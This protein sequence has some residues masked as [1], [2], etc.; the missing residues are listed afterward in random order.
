VSLELCSPEAPEGLRM[1]RK[2][3]G[4]T[5]RGTDAPEKVRKHRKR[6]GSTGRDTDAPE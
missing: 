5:G 6:Y 1:H 4:C 3:Y 2:R